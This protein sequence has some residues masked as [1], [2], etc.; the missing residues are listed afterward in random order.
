MRPKTTTKPKT[1][2]VT[3]RGTAK[4]LDTPHYPKRYEV[5]I[6]EQ[7]NGKVT[8]ERTCENMSGWELYGLLQMCLLEIE[9]Q[10][11]IKPDDELKMD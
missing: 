4:R 6:R 9:R 1:E 7:S 10:M 11:R 8:I 5:V 3:K 2:K